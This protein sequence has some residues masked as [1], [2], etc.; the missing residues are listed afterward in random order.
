LQNE[1]ARLRNDPA[2]NGELLAA[3]ALHRLEQNRK[4]TLPAI[5]AAQCLALAKQYSGTEAAEKA[6]QLANMTK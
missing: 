5:F 3:E 4:R 1:F 6:K 2:I